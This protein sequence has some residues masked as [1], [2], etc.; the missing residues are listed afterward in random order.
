MNVTEAE[1]EGGFPHRGHCSLVLRQ[2]VTRVF[3]T[4]GIASLHPTALEPTPP[5][6]FVGQNTTTKGSKFVQNNKG[7]PNAFE[8][9]KALVSTPGACQVTATADCRQT[10]G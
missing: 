9:H 1:A 2:V 8:Q 3:G 6:R 4:Y 7:V 5:G 10:C